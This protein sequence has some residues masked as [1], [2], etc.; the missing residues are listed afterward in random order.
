[1]ARTKKTKRK[2]GGYKPYMADFFV[3]PR[4]REDDYVFQ[5]GRDAGLT[6]GVV[7]ARNEAEGVTNWVD[8]DFVH[9][10]QT[11]VHGVRMRAMW[12][13]LDS[14]RVTGEDLLYLLDW[15]AVEEVFGPDMRS[16][17]EDSGSDAGPDE[18]AAGAA[19]A[20]SG[21]QGVQVN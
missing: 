6:W 9:W 3:H 16:D 20:A 19:G 18:G 7:R 8:P 14:Y 1:M 10:L 15:E 17:E 21:S 5:H 4:T 12:V 11:N 2:A 13:R